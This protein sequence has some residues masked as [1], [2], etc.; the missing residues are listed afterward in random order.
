MGLGVFV[1]VKVTVGVSVAVFVGMGV[2]VGMDV[3]VLTA[4]G[5]AGGALAPQAESTK[6]NVM[7]TDRA[8]FDRLVFIF[9]SFGK[10]E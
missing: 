8:I 10:C 2:F 7:Q 6:D 4:V 5:V 1:G 3:F 9:F